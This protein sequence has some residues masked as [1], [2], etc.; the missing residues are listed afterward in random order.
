LFGQAFFCLGD[1][2]VAAA[3]NGGAGGTRRGTRSRLTL[4]LPLVAHIALPNLG[5]AAGPLVGGDLE[6]A[7]LH[8]IAA[9]HALGGIVGDRTERGLLQGSDR[10]DGGAG[11]LGAVHAQTPAEF[12]PV[13]FNS[14]QL[15]GRNLFF[16]RH[17]VVVGEAPSFG[18]GAFARFAADAEGAVVEDSF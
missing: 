15:V 4:D 17:R 6:R 16:R 1:Q 9:P 13:R 5:K 2:G 14:G 11:G 12:V 18:A 10:T 3:A 7:R 8:A